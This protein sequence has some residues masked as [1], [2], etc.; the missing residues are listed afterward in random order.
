MDKQKYDTK[1]LAIGDIVKYKN[2]YPDEIGTTYTIIDIW[3]IESHCK[4]LMFANVPMMIKPEYTTFG[5][6][7]E[8]VK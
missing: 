1:I 8:I 4:V 6:E 7:L 5:I 3:Y 2:P